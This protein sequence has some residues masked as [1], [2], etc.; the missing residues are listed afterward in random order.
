VLF[1]SV[2][3]ASVAFVLGVIQQ[4]EL[5]TALAVL[6]GGTNLEVLTTAVAFEI[7]LGTSSSEFGVALDEVLSSIQ[8]RATPIDGSG[9][10]DS[11]ATNSESQNTTGS[12]ET[13]T[14]KKKS[15]WDRDN[16]HTIFCLI[17]AVIVFGTPVTT[18]FIALAPNSLCS[19]PRCS[20]LVPRG[21][22]QGW[23][24]SILKRNRAQPILCEQFCL[25]T[26]GRS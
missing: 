1:D 5:L 14:S 10:G 25:D 8:F 9:A 24:R 21:F 3:V 19:F 4:D 16:Q 23:P 7:P 18:V 22:W 20:F 26:T 2:W 6:L 17:W 11:N 12:N 15:I 13:K